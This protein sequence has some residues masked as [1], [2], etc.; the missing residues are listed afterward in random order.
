MIQ[1]GFREKVSVYKKYAVVHQDYTLW[2]YIVSRKFFHLSY[3]PMNEI[4]FS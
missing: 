1:Q 4:Y 3:N 2:V